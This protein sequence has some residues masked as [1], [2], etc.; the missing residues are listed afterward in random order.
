VRTIEAAVSVE[1]VRSIGGEGGWTA[2]IR[3][4]AGRIEAEAEI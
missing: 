2:W 3:E 4:Q 1:G